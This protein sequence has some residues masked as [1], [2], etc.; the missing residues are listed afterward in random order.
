MAMS[1]KAQALLTGEKGAEWNK[2]Q[3]SM[4]QAYN[5]FAEEQAKAQ[6]KQSKK[7]GWSQILGG[8]AFIATAAI[9]ASNPAGWMLTAGKLALGGKAAIAGIAATLG[10]GTAWGHHELADDVT[11]GK[12][13]EEL[14]ADVYD[15]KFNVG[16]AEIEKSKLGSDIDIDISALEAYEEGGLSTALFENIGRS[17]S[18]IGANTP[19]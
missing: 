9:L 14:M 16:Q 17:S 6:E 12:T 13:K 15:P 19:G 3:I 8:V 1:K 18:Y 4:Q 5:D 7:S 10:A 2:Y 11:L